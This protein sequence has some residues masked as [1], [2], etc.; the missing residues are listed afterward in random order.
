MCVWGAFLLGILFALSF[1]PT[2]AALFSGRLLPLA[3]KM[4]SGVILPGVFGIATGFPV[5]GFAF[6]NDGDKSVKN[7]Y[8]KLQKR[9]EK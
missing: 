9:F 3:V 8:L 7:Y 5:L 2:S 1:C 4:Q 6:L